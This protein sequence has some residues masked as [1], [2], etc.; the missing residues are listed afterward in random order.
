MSTKKDDV[1]QNRLFTGPQ[2]RAA[3]AYMNWTQEELS[4]KSGAGLS[5]IKDFE[6]ENREPYDRTVRDIQATFENIGFVFSVNSI[7]LPNIG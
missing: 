5:T 1:S 2:C 3:R 6:N 7:K 4:S